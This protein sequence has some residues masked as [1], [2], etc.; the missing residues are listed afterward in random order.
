MS[1]SHRGRGS[2]GRPEAALLP[3]LQDLAQQL[4]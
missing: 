1:V 4:P 2:G 3:A